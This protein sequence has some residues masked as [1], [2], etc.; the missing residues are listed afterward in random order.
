M[1]HRVVITGMGVVTAAGI[2]T[3]QLWS[4]VVNGFSGIDYI[5][6]FDTTHFD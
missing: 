2:G 3:E 5:E 4:A 6:S 1:K